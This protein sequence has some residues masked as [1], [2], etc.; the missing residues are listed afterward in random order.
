MKSYESHRLSTPTEISCSV[1]TVSSSRFEEASRGHKVDDLSGLKIVQMLIERGYQ[2]KS[3]KIVPDDIEMI[4]KETLRS[5]YEE[6]CDVIILTGGTGIT[7]SDVTVEALSPLFNKF[8]PGFGEM[9]RLRSFQKAKG[10]AII[11]RATAGI[12]SRRVVF[13][14]PGSPDAVETAMEIICDELPHIVKHARE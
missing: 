12:I 3:R 1:I 2:I 6:N 5:I 4:R 11:S 13:C 14:L 7:S 10:A 9:F 8:M